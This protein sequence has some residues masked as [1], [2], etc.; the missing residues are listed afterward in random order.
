MSTMGS[1]DTCRPSWMLHVIIS[2]ESRIVA[3]NDVIG[4][5]PGYRLNLGTKTRLLS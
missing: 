3:S 4:V 1:F 5:L 2:F